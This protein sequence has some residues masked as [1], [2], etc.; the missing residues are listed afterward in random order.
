MFVLVEVQLSHYI[1]TLMHA[2]IFRGIHIALHSALA[3]SALLSVSGHAIA[4][5]VH[6][7]YT[8]S[9]INTEMPAAGLCNSESMH[10]VIMQG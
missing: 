9:W 7:P 6:S 4:L 1:A 3:G 5:S 10:G 2:G 8:N